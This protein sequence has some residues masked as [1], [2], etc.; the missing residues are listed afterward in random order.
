MSRKMPTVQDPRTKPASRIG[1]YGNRLKDY[2]LAT[3]PEDY[4]DKLHGQPPYFVKYDGLLEKILQSLEIGATQEDAALAAGVSGD[5]FRQWLRRGRRAREKLEDGAMPETLGY[6]DPYY[7]SLVE[8]METKEAEYKIMLLRRIQDAG[9]DQW[10]PNAWILERRWSEEF[11]TRKTVK[12]E[13]EVNH[14]TKFT[15]DLGDKT[16]DVIEAQKEPIDADYQ[17]EEETGE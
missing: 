7:I 1:Q 16:K 2:E 8:I 4:D 3:L 10:Q 13:G 11:S 6:W 15:L 14:N 12:H 17:I 5:T 9:E